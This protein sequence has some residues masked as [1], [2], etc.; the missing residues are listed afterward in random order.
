MKE[1]KVRVIYKS[2]YTD[3]PNKKLISNYYTL[4]ELIFG[5]GQIDFTSGGYLELNEMEPE[6]TK[7]EL[8][9]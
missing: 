1:I 2:P 9:P 3:T 8:L 5:G 6:Y 7:F 4:H